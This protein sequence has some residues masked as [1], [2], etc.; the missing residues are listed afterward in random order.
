MSIHKVIPFA[1]PIWMFSIEDNFQAEIDTCY[2]Y[3]AKFASNKLSN[4]GGYQSQ[5]VALEEHFLP[6]TNKLTPVLRA[7]ADDIGMVFNI[8]N[9]W[10]NINRKNNFNSPHLHPNSAFSGV[11]YLKTNAAS[12]KII[13]FNPTMSEAFPINNQIE[14]FWGSYFFE[15]KVG[16]VLVFPSYLRHYV[17]PNFSDEDRI[18]IAFNMK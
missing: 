1:T 7:V 18:S 8:N 3:E 14:H 2:A 11:V 4:V 17:E 10:L 5:N 6:L 13:F 16:D 15:P 12:G 9:A